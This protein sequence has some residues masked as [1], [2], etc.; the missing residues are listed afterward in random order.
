MLDQMC[1]LVRTG[2][3]HVDSLW[4]S[5][6]AAQEASGVMAAAMLQQQSVMREMLVWE[7]EVEEVIREMVRMV[8]EGESTL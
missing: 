6:L 3:Q 2:V 1:Q 4:G 8:E 7:S 5:Q